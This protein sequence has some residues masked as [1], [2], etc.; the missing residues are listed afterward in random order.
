MDDVSCELILYACPVGELAIQLDAY[1]ARTCAEFGPNAAHRY[2]PHVTL[3]GFFHD[4]VAAIPIYIQALTVALAAAPQPPK[5][6]ITGATF[7]PTFHGVL[8][9]SPWLV[10]LTRTFARLAHSPTR[11]DA[12]RL[13]DWL[14][15]SLAYDFSPEHHAPLAECGRAM[16]DITASVW[17]ELRLYERY[18]VNEWRCH[19]AHMLGLMDA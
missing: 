6:T 12:L 1:Y 9:E 15:L 4:T 14:H 19:C 13:K 10:D 17:W 18:S 5:I 7:T 16:V 8:I 11:R 3:T 2:P